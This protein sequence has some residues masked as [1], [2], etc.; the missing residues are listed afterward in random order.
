MS[1]T[2]F[3]SGG[4]CSSNQPL[5]IRIDQELDMLHSSFR[6]HG[7]PIGYGGM[8]ELQRE[9]QANHSQRAD[10]TILPDRTR[11]AT[12][13]AGASD[14]WSDD[15]RREIAMAVRFPSWLACCFQLVEHSSR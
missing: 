10:T 5:A 4:R 15:A 3:T 12:A 7:Q 11:S 14:R 8:R 1:R 9:R 13:A 2:F 6:G